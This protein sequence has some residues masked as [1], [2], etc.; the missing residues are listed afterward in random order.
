[1]G[2]FLYEKTET[3]GIRFVSQR[4]VGDVRVP[5][6]VY[7]IWLP[8]I[9]TRGVAVYSVF[10]R[11]ERE[12]IVKGITLNDVAKAC[13]IG[14]N[15]LKDTI[16]Q[17]CECGFIIYTPPTG[18]QRLMHW[19]SE[20][21][22]LEPPQK[23]SGELIE[24]YAHPQGYQPLSTWL[25][26]PVLLDSKP[27]VTEQCDEALLDSKPKIASLGVASLGVVNTGADAPAAP[28]TF[29]EAFDSEPP[30]PSD[31]PT[32]TAQDLLTEEGRDRVRDRI[33]N[34]RR[35]TIAK[36]SWHDLEASCPTLSEYS[37]PVSVP[38]AFVLQV[39]AAL[40]RE[41]VPLDREKK[42]AVRFWI[43]GAE[44]IGRK[45]DW[46]ID[47]VE[48]ALKNALQAGLSIKGPQSI[49]YAVSDVMVKAQQQHR[50][51]LMA[52]GDGGMVTVL[53]KITD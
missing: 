22:V 4:R 7:D 19:T 28:L 44:S 5:N 36:E 29:E 31:L 52:G 46:Q 32:T 3:G 1:M 23:V 48:R 42:S 15:S 34:A 18:Q 35:E 43:R 25:V 24:K 16:D 39:I 51:P 26:T 8:I 37:A 38:K 13:R 17:L 9:G 30:P 50:R 27:C 45:C 49:D 11:L 47:V 6:F 33:L 10:C 41:G 2:K 20:I 53:T 21:V 14:P 40:I 12:R